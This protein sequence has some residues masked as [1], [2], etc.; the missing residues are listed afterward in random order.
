M[1]ILTL[2]FPLQQI[3]RHIFQKEN[4]KSEYKITTQV[5]I[6]IASQLPANP[7]LNKLFRHPT[8]I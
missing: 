8:E 5:Q 4:H 6:Y 2:N 7:R 1:I 3:K